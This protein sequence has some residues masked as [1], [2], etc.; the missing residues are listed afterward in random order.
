MS[1][2]SPIMLLRHVW[3]RTVYYPRIR[4][5]FAAVETGDAS[6]EEAWDEVHGV[7]PRVVSVDRVNWFVLSPWGM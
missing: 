7:A 1:V 2:E 4:A 5:K 3:M 6:T